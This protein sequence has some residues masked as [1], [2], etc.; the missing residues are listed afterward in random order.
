MQ[1]YKSNVQRK[2]IEKI[3]TKERDC[4]K[5]SNSNNNKKLDQGDTQRMEMKGQI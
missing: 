3:V 5:N 2:Y 4:F 1:Y